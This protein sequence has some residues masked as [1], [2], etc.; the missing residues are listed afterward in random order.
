VNECVR[1][2]SSDIIHHMGIYSITI[3]HLAHTHTHKTYTHAQT[4][5]LIV[6]MDYMCALSANILQS[7]VGTN[8]QR[9]RHPSTTHTLPYSTPA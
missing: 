3:A 6:R 2:P 8:D 7:D 4:R 9:N 5:P 1:Q